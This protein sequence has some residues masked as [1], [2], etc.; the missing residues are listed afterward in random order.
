MEIQQM[1]R[2]S[3]LKEKLIIKD[4]VMALG[5][6]WHNED[7]NM[8]FEGL[9]SNKFNLDLLTLVYN[10]ATKNGTEKVDMHSLSKQFTKGQ[11]RKI[12]AICKAKTQ[13]TQQKRMY[14]LMHL[15]TSGVYSGLFNK[16]QLEALDEFCKTH[17][18]QS[19]LV[20][21]NRVE[22]MEAELNNLLASM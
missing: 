16:K 21:V 14:S 17:N 2:L 5:D 18:L 8:L 1:T 19:G 11:L 3:D 4:K 10:L 12:N 13:E 15:L 22:R 6:D 7:V 20:R 9:K